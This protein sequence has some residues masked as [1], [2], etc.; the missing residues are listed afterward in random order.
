M[1]RNVIAS[2]EELR[3][4][5]GVPGELAVKKVIHHLDSH[6][7]DFISKSPFLVMST[8]DREGNCDVSPR[9]D[10]AGF[11]LTHNEKYLV[12]PERPGNKRIDS[13]KNILQN[14]QVGLLFLIPNLKETLRING[15]ATI[16]RDEE[17]LERMAANG[18]KPIVGIAVE[19]KECFIQCGKAIL[20]SELWK[21][22]TWL[23]SEAL[24][25]AAK[26]LADHANLPEIDEMAMK[27][28]LEEG[29]KK[30]MY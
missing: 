21:S 1:F 27:D 3:E 8:A 18:K 23:Q 12:I 19:V 5:V 10:K 2:E 25:S 11:V 14:P 15:K 30:R 7:R 26:I 4:L 17:I 16:I 9:G 6:C 22:E 24:P 29:Y 20:R 28:R 13:L